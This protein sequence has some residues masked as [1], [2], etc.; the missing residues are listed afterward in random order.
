VLEG[1]WGSLPGPR[2]ASVRLSETH[3]VSPA[4]GSGDTMAITFDADTDMGGTP[5]GSTV[6][7]AVLETGLLWS[8]ASGAPPY[9][10]AE[11]RWTNNRTLTL[12]VLAVN[13]SAPRACPL[14]GGGGGLNVT[15]RP[16][17]GVRDAARL[18]L[19]SDDIAVAVGCDAG[20]ADGLY[21]W[22]NAVDQAL[23]V[24][25]G[26]CPQLGSVVA[27][28]R[29][30]RGRAGVAGPFKG[31]QVLQ[32]AAAAV[33]SVALR[34]DGVVLAWGSELLGS[35]SVD[36]PQYL[37]GSPPTSLVTA[38]SAGWEHA[39]L[40]MD[41]GTLR[42]FGRDTNGQL[43]GADTDNIEPQP[44]GG[45]P[46][47]G[48]TVKLMA[49]GAQ[50]SLVITDDGRASALRLEPDPEPEPEH[51]HEHEHKPEPHP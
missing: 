48:T 39:L 9:T 6:D 47:S 29:P 22:G 38:L 14:P 46:P 3:G 25:D 44:V 33:F 27:A 4:L 26:R 7:P 20:S 30:V 42:G 37:F 45:L 10:A 17:L 23:G 8:T 43:G 24:A 41:D 16:A 40:L 35:A 49:A 32:L 36:S 12:R 18:S 21:A 31:E 50:H 15:V 13:T 34:A 28:P 2:V 1:D 11:A 51:E 19:A 5:L